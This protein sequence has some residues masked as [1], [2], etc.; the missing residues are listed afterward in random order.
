MRPLTLP[1][2]ERAFAALAEVLS[3]VS[4]AMLDLLDVGHAVRPPA[5]VV[6]LGEPKPPGDPDQHVVV[7][8]SSL[9]EFTHPDVAVAMPAGS[10]PG[11]DALLYI[12][13]VIRLPI[14]SRR[15][16]QGQHC[17]EVSKAAPLGGRPQ[18]SLASQD[19]LSEPFVPAGVAV[20]RQLGAP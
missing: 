8:R 6:G 4:A 15:I 12:G 11:P 5:E 14:D 20:N 2:S 9:L 18:Q 7:G 13:D 17:Q 10:H 16:G 19:V 3:Q 1:E